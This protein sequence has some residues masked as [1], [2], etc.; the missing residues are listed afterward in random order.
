I[1]E[2]E[3]YNL[4]NNSEIKKEA[5]SSDRLKKIFEP[6]L[7]NLENNSEIKKEAGSSDRLK[8][9]DKFENCLEN[10]NEFEKFENINK[11]EN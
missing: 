9:I 3:L 2:P 1:F 7:Y 11:F 10:N 5:G 4:E 6:E 8:S